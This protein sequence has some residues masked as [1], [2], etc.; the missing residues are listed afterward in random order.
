LHKRFANNELHHHQLQHKK[1]T[2]TNHEANVK[3]KNKVLKK[4]NDYRLL[5]LAMQPTTKN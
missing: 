5:V 1:Q 4:V 3:I 2:K